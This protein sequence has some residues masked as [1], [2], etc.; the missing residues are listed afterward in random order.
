MVEAGEPDP[1]E[2]FVALLKIAIQSDNPS[3][4]D[5]TE[6]RFEQSPSWSFPAPRVEAAVATLD[7]C[8][9]RPDLY[10]RLMGDIDRL[11]DDA[12]PATRLQAATH[13]IRLWDIDRPGFWS[14]LALRLNSETNFGV[15][16]DVVGLL[17]QVLNADPTQTEA[18]LLAVISRFSGTANEVRC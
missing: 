12:H 6:A 18:Q 2:Q 1:A 5:D 17:G 9:P 13:L 8:L 14:R 11:L 4:D 3:V 15:L 10:S 7:A 16:S